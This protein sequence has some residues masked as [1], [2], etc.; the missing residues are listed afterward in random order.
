MGTIVLT[1]K[2]DSMN[3]FITARLHPWLNVCALPRTSTHKARCFSITDAKNSDAEISDAK[4]EIGPDEINPNFVNRNPRNLEQ[5]GLARKRRGWRFQYPTVNFYHRLKVDFHGKATTAQVEHSNG[6][7]VLQ[8]STREV[9]IARHLYSAV[10]VSAA[11][12]IG[13]VL[14]QRCREA[15]ITAMI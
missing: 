13:H 7:I 9:C 6:D 10:D 12:N 2:V 14:A 1:Y 3:R 11:A 5:M 15:G 8:A 4:S